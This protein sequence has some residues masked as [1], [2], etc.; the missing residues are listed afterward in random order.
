MELSEEDIL[1]LSRLGHRIDEF[2]SVGPDGIARLRNV[3]GRCFFLSQDGK[4]CIVYAHR[5]LGCDIYPVNC[6]Q[7]GHVFVD[8]FCKA[9]GTV[10]KQELR[11]KGDIL[12]RHIA[13]IDKEAEGRKKRK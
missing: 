11:A 4:A 6:D 12:R 1:V 5:P 7:R 13:V 2:C 10:T 3:K 9:K 8:D